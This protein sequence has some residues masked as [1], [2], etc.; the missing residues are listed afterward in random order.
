MS[1]VLFL[2]AALASSAS[3][4]SGILGANEE[5][6]IGEID[7]SI[8]E[9]VVAPPSAPDTV[10]VSRLFVVSL[11]TIGGGCRRVGETEVRVV[12]NTAFVTPYDYRGTGGRTCTLGLKPFIHDTTVRFDVVGQAL[13]L[14]TAQDRDGVQFEIELPVWVR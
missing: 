10:A 8:P 14:I 4:G 1:R 13:V 3:C 7:L 6:V 12:G 11:L 9:T 2:L 5:R